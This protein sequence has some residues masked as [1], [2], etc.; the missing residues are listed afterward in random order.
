MWFPCKFCFEGGF[1]GIF[2]L[3]F[4]GEDVGL[5]GGG[6]VL[7]FLFIC[8]VVVLFGFFW[9]FSFVWFFWGVFLRVL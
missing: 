1:L 8:F 7:F 9:C 5:L 6:F 3:V 2:L 4:G